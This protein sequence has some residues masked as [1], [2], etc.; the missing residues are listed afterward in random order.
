M[1]GT[2]REAGG[3]VK[4]TAAGLTIAAGPAGQSIVFRCRLTW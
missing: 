2:G 1:S 3:V 4:L